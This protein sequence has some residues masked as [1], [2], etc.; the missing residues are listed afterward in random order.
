MH[1][2]RPRFSLRWLMVVV[3]VLGLSL[4]LATWRNRRSDFFHSLARMNNE[5]SNSLSTKNS[6]RTPIL[7]KSPPVAFGLL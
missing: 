3:T 1:L 2:P 7:R 5:N 4:G 6:L